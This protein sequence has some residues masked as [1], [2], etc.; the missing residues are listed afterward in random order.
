MLEKDIN[1]KLD[2][3]ERMLTEQNI[4][5]KEVLNFKDACHYLR[6]SQSHLY[7]LTSSKSIP[8]FCP[9]GKKLYFKRQELDEWLL[10]NPCTTR[11]DIEKKANEYLTE[12]KNP[13][14]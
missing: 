4:L 6:L 12:R 14:I 11:E 7:K 2:N 1:R 10:R 9:R 3:I 5:Q 13:I 8:H